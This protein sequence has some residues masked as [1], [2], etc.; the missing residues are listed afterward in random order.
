VFSRYA[1]AADEIAAWELSRTP[2][3]ESRSRMVE[4]VVVG[5]VVFESALISLRRL[6]EEHHS[7]E[8]FEP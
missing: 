4:A 6:A 2:P 5:T 3:A 1:A 7:A 8:R